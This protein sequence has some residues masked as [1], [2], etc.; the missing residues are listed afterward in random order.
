M[1]QIAWTAT[2]DRATSIL[3]I[4]NSRCL[5]GQGGIDQLLFF[6]FMAQGPLTATGYQSALGL[7]AHG[8]LTRGI[9]QLL[10]SVLTDGALTAKTRGRAVSVLRIH[11]SKSLDNDGISISFRAYVVLMAHGAL[12]AKG[13]RSASVLRVVCT[14]R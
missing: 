14:V 6:V 12:T 5:D 11:G 3:R 13:D 2:G 4:H 8:A 9:K 7:M 10:S 1:A